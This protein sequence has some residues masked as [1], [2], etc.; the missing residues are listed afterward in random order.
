[1]VDAG[2]EFWLSASSGSEMYLKGD[3]GNP[4]P[5]G[6]KNNTLGVDSY[7]F[8]TRTDAKAHARSC[9]AEAAICPATV[10]G[11]MSSSDGGPPAVDSQPEAATEVLAEEPGAPARGPELHT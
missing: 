8:S 10:G 4:I 9:R 11:S 1:M 7:I 2:A 6:R 5:L 3:R